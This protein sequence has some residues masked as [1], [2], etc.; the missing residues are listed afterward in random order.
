MTK[1]AARKAVLVSWN[2]VLNPRA[3]PKMG[4][5]RGFTP[6]LLR[7][8][9]DRRNRYATG[10]S[11]VRA[12]VSE[13][14][15]DVD[16]TIRISQGLDHGMDPKSR[17]QST[18]RVYRPLARAIGSSHDDPVTGFVHGGRIPGSKTKSCM[19]AGRVEGSTRR[20]G[21][22]GYEGSLVYGFTN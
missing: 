18:R 11:Q 16:R 13:D 20:H 14:M 12:S 9:A 17:G 5:A 21:G 3:N 7:E 2:A 1:A 19:D 22:S 15:R 6:A 4:R 8:V 10:V